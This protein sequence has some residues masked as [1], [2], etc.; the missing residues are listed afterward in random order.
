MF[1]P[2]ANTIERN[3][4]AGKRPGHPVIYEKTDPMLQRNPNL[5]NGLRNAYD[6]LMRVL[7]YVARRYVKDREIAIGIVH[8]TLCEFHGKGVDFGLESTR[9]LLYRAVSRDCID[10]LRKAK[11]AMNE[12]QEWALTM[13]PL[14]EDPFFNEE[15]IRA[16]RLR[17]LYEQLNTLGKK[18][19]AYLRAYMTGTRTL[20][21]L[22]DQ[23]GVKYSSIVNSKN[24]AI[25]VLIERLRENPDML[26]ILCTLIYTIEKM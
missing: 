15:V 5:D 3:D 21:E 12:H 14:E 10:Y 1:L 22:A 7:T 23:F 19:A 16:E 13:A 11:K 26:F 9:K 6:E 8:E 25:E 24:D 17:W 4:S 18:Q 20:A 2:Y